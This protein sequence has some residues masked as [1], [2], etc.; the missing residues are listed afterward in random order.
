ML[1]PVPSYASFYGLASRVIQ[2]FEDILEQKIAAIA[3]F[4]VTITASA[5]ANNNT[6]PFVTIDQFQQRSASSRSLS[7]SYLLQL[8]PIITD[9]TRLAWE[10]YSRT[11]QAWL[12]EARVYQA[13][14]GIG[15]GIVDPVSSL[16]TTVLNPVIIRLDENLDGDLDPGVSVRKEK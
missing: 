8:V 4:G 2:S 1:Q 14:K 12:H 5:I 6:W 10:E 3:A 11:N 15:E 16:A 7:G 13:E 9:E